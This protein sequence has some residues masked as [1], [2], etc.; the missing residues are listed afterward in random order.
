MNQSS[1]AQINE[2]SNKPRFLISDLCAYLESYLSVEQ[3]REVYRSYVFSAEAHEGQ[4]RLSGEPYIY[5][6]LAVARILADIRLDYRC[7]MAAIMHD[8][9]EDT[10]VTKAQLEEEF[11]EEVT[12]L[13]DGVSKLNQ[14]NFPSKA[15]AQ[16]ASFR[17]MLLAM[18]QDIRIILIKLADRLHNMRTLEVMR[19]EK[20]R[21]IAR[22]TLEIYAPIAHRLGIYR[23]RTELE[24]LCFAAYWPMRYRAL[25]EAV[26]AARGNRKEVM[27]N[28]D[29]A[30]V[31]R[32]EQEGIVGVVR[33]R[34]K[35]L[36]SIYTKMRDKK[37][38]FSEVV[39][40]YA[41]RIIVDRLDTCYRVLGVVH[42]LYKPVPGRFKDYIAIPKANGYQSLHTLLFGPHGLPIEIQIRTVEMDRMADSGIAAH[43]LYKSSENQ[44]GMA[45]ADASNWLKNLL[46]LQKDAGDSMEFLEHVK[47]DLFPDEVYVFTPRGKIMVL[48]KGAT[49]IDFA[50][51]VH[52]DVGNHTVAAR[53]DRHMVPLRTR[54]YSGQTVEV[55]TS[56]TAN[57]SAAWLNFVVTGKARANI[58]GYLK[59]LRHQEAITLGR[60]LLNKELAQH[61]L[62]IDQIPLESL[63]Q[64]LKDFH[65]T[66]KDTLLEE[67]GLGNRM[68][69][70]VA[71]RLIDSAID[72]PKGEAAVPSADAA[73]LAITGTEGMV[74]R[75]GKCCRPLPGDEIVAI[76]NPGKGI[77]VHRH[78]C[79]NLGDF[80]K[81]DSWLD[82]NWEKEPVGD[83]TTEI[84][85]DVGNKRGA[86]AAVASAI[87]EMGANIKN[88]VMEERDGLTSTLH[89]IVAVDSRKH[90]A[91]I[92]RRLRLLKTVLRIHRVG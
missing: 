64:L 63:A 19:P 16:A 30:L 60:R 14:I 54:L 9:L 17:K 65:L 83:F 41:F 81:S 47:V 10:S 15:E 4:K 29:A 2:K 78:E 69:F 18:T 48:A 22:E 75:F 40:V 8:V 62:N 35:H 6:P 3:V 55:I 89:F 70:L 23:L 42:N 58:R 80:R 20:C 13:V 34:E 86:L 1:G 77:V 90:L 46:E 21:R 50:Y 57:P 49:V 74:V 61:E 51:A 38:S 52:S 53:V 87:S 79:R 28:I 91:N 12:T 56:E 39:D 5:H 24:E 68:P 72:L 82:V 36:Y 84:K 11:G 37:R 67:I 76:F 32:L 73:P 45:Q 7:L 71:R 27:S 26:K 59:N 85:V 92:M 33:G 66:T 88:V 25:K 43:W 44:S 31:G